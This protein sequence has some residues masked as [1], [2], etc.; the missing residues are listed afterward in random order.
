MQ[1]M[2]SAMVLVNQISSVTLL[3]LVAV[4]IFSKKARNDWRI[5]LVMVICIALFAVDSVVRL[6]VFR[7]SN[8]GM[9]GLLVGFYIFASWLGFRHVKKLRAAQVAANK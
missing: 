9:D 5:S 3:W 7:Q 8:G 6:L 1:A 2:Q 4:S